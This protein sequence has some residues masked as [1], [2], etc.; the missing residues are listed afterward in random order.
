[1]VN[2]ELKPSYEY[3][4]RG[5]VKREE[6][7][8]IRDGD[9]SH[10]YEHMSGRTCPGAKSQPLFERCVNLFLPLTADASTP[11]LENGF[12]RNSKGCQVHV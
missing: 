6:K 5:F 8:L 7:R 4:V 12:Q 2:Y 1:M 3:Q 11:S 10:R 9:R